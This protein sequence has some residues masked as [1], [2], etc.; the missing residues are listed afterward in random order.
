M[1][2][3]DWEWGELVAKMWL[4]LAIFKYLGP[5]GLEGRQIG[6]DEVFECVVHY[7][8]LVAYVRFGSFLT[9]DI[10]YSLEH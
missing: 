9:G 10:V 4:E 6:A 3:G 2:F 1:D 5:L 7:A 8:L